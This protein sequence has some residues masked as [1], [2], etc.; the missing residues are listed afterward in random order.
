MRPSEETVLPVL[1]DEVKVHKVERVTARV[2]VRKTVHSEE[3]RYELPPLE[4]VEIEVERVPIGRVVE[5]PAATRTEGEVTIV[6][7]HEERWV[8]TRQL[9]LTEE[10]RLRRRRSTLP[11]AAQPVTQRREQVDVV[12]LPA[13]DDDPTAHAARLA[14][15]DAVPGDP[16]TD[17][18]EPST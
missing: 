5:A 1:Q 3:V 16:S 15:P 10:L 17:E 14:A 2:Q 7:V 9:V 12:R 11:V 6:P 13:T 18:R 4:R 8:M